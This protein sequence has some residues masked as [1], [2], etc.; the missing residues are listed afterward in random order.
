MEQQII[1]VVITGIVSGALS[2]FGTIK[3]LR[4][5]IEYLKANLAEVKLSVHDAHVRI[6]KHVTDGSKHSA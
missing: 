3:A 5:H 6:N 1:M 2:S 4:I